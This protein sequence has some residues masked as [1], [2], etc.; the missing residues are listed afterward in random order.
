VLISDTVPASLPKG[1]TSVQ[2]T[3]TSWMIEHFLADIQS[4]NVFFYSPQNNNKSNS[5]HCIHFV[6]FSLPLSFFPA[7]KVSAPCPAVFPYFPQNLHLQSGSRR[8][9]ST[10]S[11]LVTCCTVRT[12]DK[13]VT[14]PPWHDSTQWVRISSLA[15]RHHYTQTHQTR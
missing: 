13:I 10:P 9:I 4:S 12:A 7:F 15:R 8:L 11:Q 6:F 1:F 14:F 3:F 5:S 2:P